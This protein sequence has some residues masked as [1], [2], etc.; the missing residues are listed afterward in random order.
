[1]IGDVLK[2]IHKIMMAQ[3]ITAENTESNLDPI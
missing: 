2:D 3:F 1:M